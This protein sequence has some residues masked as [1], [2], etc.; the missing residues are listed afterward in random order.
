MDWT[1]TWKNWATLDRG[2]K[3]LKSL[4]ESFSFRSGVHRSEYATKNH[5]IYVEGAYALQ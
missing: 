3:V 2:K 5:C 4:S 1:D